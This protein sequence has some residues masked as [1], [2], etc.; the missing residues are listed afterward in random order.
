MKIRDDMHE[1]TV[2]LL[3]TGD[4]IF[5]RAS[6]EIRR[7]SI[8]IHDGWTQF[9][10]RRLSLLPGFSRWFDELMHDRVG[11]LFIKY[12]GNSRFEIGL[13]EFGPNYWGNALVPEPRPR[14]PNRI[15]VDR[16]I[17]GVDEDSDSEDAN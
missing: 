7:R 13:V 6:C 8:R 1:D 12:K 2:Y 4:H 11:S 16:V 10:D 14:P 9:Y 17:H 3:Q 5:F 15:V